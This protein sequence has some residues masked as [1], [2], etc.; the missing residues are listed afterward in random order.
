[1]EKL[2]EKDLLPLTE[3]VKVRDGWRQEIIAYKKHRR[4][5]A[6]EW[7]TF[8]FEN[9]RT[10]RWQV[11]EMIR[12]EH[13]TDPEAIAG[14]LAVYNELVPAPGDLVATMMVAF[15]STDAVR[16]EMPRFLGTDKAVWLVIGGNEVHG[17]PEAG[18]AEE[19]RISA[20]QYVTFHLDAAAQAALAKKGTEVRLEIRTD[21]YPAKVELSEETR[22]SLA[23]D[24]AG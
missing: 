11:M 8:L 15:S 9:R 17:E 3:Y 13:M 20:V 4:V 7:I 14:E 21:G 19:E 10:M 16:E 2:T 23:E 22:A 5:R 1:M 6:G 24:L 12:A 18:R